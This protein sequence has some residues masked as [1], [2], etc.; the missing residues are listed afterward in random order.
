MWVRLRNLSTLFRYSRI[1]STM[2]SS[3]T[4]SS[5]FDDLF[6]Q[7]GRLSLGSEAEKHVAP[8]PSQVQPLP[9]LEIKVEQELPKKSPFQGFEI[10]HGHSR[11]LSAREEQVDVND[12][13]VSCIDIFKACGYNT[14]EFTLVKKA[15]K[16]KDIFDVKQLTITHDWTMDHQVWMMVGGAENMGREDRNL[17]PMIPF[18]YLSGFIKHSIHSKRGLTS[19]TRAD[20]LAKFGLDSAMEN[21]VPIEIYLVDQLKLFYP[22]LPIE[23]QVRFDRFRLDAVIKSERLVKNI[24]IEID[25]MGHSNYNDTNER[26]KSDMVQSKGMMLVRYSVPTRYADFQT[27]EKAIKTSNYLTSF[28]KIV[29]SSIQFKHVL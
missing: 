24:A 6:H 13:Y 11:P 2:I 18:K 28:L 16:L 5:P 25:E 23:T 1:K 3:S 21:Q 22:D 12:L 10:L 29:Q 7:F 26:I 15:M 19:Q 9:T 14:S 8:S 20:L 27:L 4:L 17:Y